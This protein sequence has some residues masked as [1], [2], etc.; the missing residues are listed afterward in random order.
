MVL[1]LEIRVYLF[2]GFILPMNFYGVFVI[3]VVNGG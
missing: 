2:N 3:L 1:I